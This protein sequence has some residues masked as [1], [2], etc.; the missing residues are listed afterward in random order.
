M[1]YERVTVVLSEYEMNEL[2]KIARSELRRPRDQAAY[3]L[4]RVLLG[5]G[6]API[7]IN[8]KAPTGLVSQAETV[9]AFAGITNS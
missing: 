2:R 8:N 1:T 9:S 6:N 7:P 5:E 4:R 3:L